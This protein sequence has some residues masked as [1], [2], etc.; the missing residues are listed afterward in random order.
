MNAP[1]DQ[2]ADFCEVFGDVLA[3][4]TE[5]MDALADEYQRQQLASVNSGS[6]DESPED[7]G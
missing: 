6:E 4:T 3:L 1:R 2:W 7:I 5:Q